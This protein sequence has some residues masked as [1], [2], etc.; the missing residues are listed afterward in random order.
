M[1]EVARDLYEKNVANPAY[2]GSRNTLYNE[3]AREMKKKPKISELTNFLLHERIY[4]QYKQRRKRFPRRQ[5]VRKSVLE[6]VQCDLADFQALKPFSHGKAF[7]LVFVCI[8]SKFV[9]LY[10]LSKKSKPEMETAMTEILASLPVKRSIHLMQ[11][12][13]GKGG[14]K[15]LTR[16]PRQLDRERERERESERD[17]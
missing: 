1:D 9:K 5:I 8:F 15:E 4:G 10:A 12:D 11:T 17:N 16:L 13:R 7:L 2:L 6:S 3:I 14:S